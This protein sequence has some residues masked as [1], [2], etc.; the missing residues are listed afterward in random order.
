VRQL[1][2]HTVAIAAA[3]LGD[4]FVITVDGIEGGRDSY[5]GVL[6]AGV[7]GALIKYQGD[8]V[9]TVHHMMTFRLAI[10]LPQHSAKAQIPLAGRQQSPFI[11]AERVDFASRQALE[12]SF[13]VLL[14]C[15]NGQD[16][17]LNLEIPTRRLDSQQR[18]RF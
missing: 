4:K 18:V 3:H 9:R 14:L 15:T 13:S 12:I 17:P 1:D 5:P 10:D 6:Q 11:K 7:A 2:K 8:V 16:S